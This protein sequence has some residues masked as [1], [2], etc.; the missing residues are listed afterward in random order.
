MVVEVAADCTVLGYELREEDDDDE[1]KEEMKEDEETTKK[2][3][4]FLEFPKK[5]GFVWDLSW[6]G[7]IK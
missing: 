7:N 4:F 1:E 5:V 3:E 6:V 2:D